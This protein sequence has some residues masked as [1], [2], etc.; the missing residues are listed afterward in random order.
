MVFT[1]GGS[2]P[3]VEG[4]GI[5]TPDA[6]LPGQRSWP[7]CAPLRQPCAPVST[8]HPPRVGPD[9]SRRA[10]PL[11]RWSRAAPHLHCSAAVLVDHGSRPETRVLRR[12]RCLED[13]R[14]PQG[15]VVHPTRARI[16]PPR[17]NTA[18]VP[19]RSCALIYIY[20]TTTITEDH[21]RESGNRHHDVGPHRQHFR[22]TASA[23]LY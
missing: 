17:P 8:P 1:R 13:P 11:N 14:E 21:A 5:E 19:P 2:L 3:H 7:L 20:T 6:A 18:T 22:A 23:L 10:Q 4:R 9:H 12:A 15:S 16:I